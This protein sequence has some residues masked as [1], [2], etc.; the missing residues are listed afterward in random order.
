MKRII[1][2]IEV[3]FSKALDS[4]VSVVIRESGDN[5]TRIVFEDNQRNVQ[6]PDSLFSI[7]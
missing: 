2:R 7:Q 5:W 1:S 4:V 6:L 3:G